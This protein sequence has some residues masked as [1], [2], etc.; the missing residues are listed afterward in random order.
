MI[1]IIFPY[2]LPFNT[3]EPIFNRLVALNT[4]ESIRVAIVNTPPTI[5]HVLQ[6]DPVV[7]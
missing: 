5:A 3:E 2:P 6:I 4:K 7:D 1:H